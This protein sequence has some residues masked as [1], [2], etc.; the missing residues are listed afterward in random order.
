M[1][2]IIKTKKL[3]E[4]YQEVQMK[5]ELLVVKNQEVMRLENELEKAQRK[6]GEMHEITNKLVELEKFVE[7]QNKTITYKDDRNVELKKANKIVNSL[8]FELV[9]ENELLKHEILRLEQTLKNNLVLFEY[10]DHNFFKHNGAF[11]AFPMTKW[12]AYF[13]A[14]I[15][16]QRKYEF[17]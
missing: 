11:A 10:Y 4:Y 7:N 1:I 9:E 12:E 14:V 8:N 5:H 17:V 13:E 2:T 16:E 15:K 6:L 3:N